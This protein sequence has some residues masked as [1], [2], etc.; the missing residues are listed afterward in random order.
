MKKT[1]WMVAVTVV[2]CFVFSA[3]AVGEDNTEVKGLIT[4]RSAD[5]MTVRTSDG[6]T[7]EVVL[8]DDT[9]VRMPK[10]LGLRHKEVAWTSLI[11]GLAVTVK[12]N[13]NTQGKLV[14]T[15]VDFTKE[16]LQTAS[17][18]QAG[19]APTQRQVETNQQNIAANQQNSAANQQNIEANRQQITANERE[20][21]ERFAS[22]ADY[23]V[24]SEVTVY[25]KPGSSAISD[26][27]KAALSQMAASATKLQGYLIEVKGFADS[28]GAAAMNQTLSRDRAEAVI[29]YMMQSCNVPARHL[30][31]PG[32]M[33]ISDPAASNETTAGRADNRRTDVKVLVNKG[34]SGPGGQ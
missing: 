20:T 21:D 28:T 30:L 27:D 16:S 13:P 6:T 19:L 7:H 29:D 23:D 2:L 8:T 18:I 22:L 17:M 24:K 32:A 25:F 11:P 31:A 5:T 14:A 26:K 4:G 33:G 34:I 12:G 1:G 10:G 15:Q 9:K 3:L